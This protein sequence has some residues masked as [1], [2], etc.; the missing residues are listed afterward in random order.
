MDKIGKRYFYIITSTRNWDGL[1]NDV[2]FITTNK[3]EA[4]SRFQWLYS[5]RVYKDFLDED[6][7]E[8]FENRDYNFN[9][10]R[11]DPERISGYFY[12]S[13]YDGECDYR[14]DS[15]KTNIFWSYGGK[16]S[17]LENEYR[18]FCNRDTI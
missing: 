15:I 11:N 8:N 18:R 1:E 12:Y 3:K 9:S 6:G 7:E 16:N 5:E 2:N 13:D 17:F 4:I 10:N 14:L